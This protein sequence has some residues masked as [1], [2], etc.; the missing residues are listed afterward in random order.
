MTLQ[1]LFEDW[2]NGRGRVE[3]LLAALVELHE[4]AEPRAEAAAPRY[5][6]GPTFGVNYAEIG[7]A[8]ERNDEGMV[9]ADDWLA[10][11]EAEWAR[12]YPASW[13]NKWADRLIA[14]AR[15]AEV[16]RKER[17]AAN[18]KLAEAEHERDGAWATPPRWWPAPLR[19]M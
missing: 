8:E 15:E 3:A 13:Q 4:P 1:K 2:V 12:A 14:A 16:L 18:A 9:K 17:D 19:N 10:E 7:D 11:C 6:V 5:K